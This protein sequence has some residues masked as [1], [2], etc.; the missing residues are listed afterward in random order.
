MEFRILGPLE[1][2]DNGQRLTLG[3]P[4]PRAVLA[5]LLLRAN[6]VVPAG[7]L[8]EALWGE[9][10]PPTA[11]T[12]VQVY[13]SR[14]RR[15][16]QPQKG[17]TR[18]DHIL[19]TRPPGYLLRVQPGGL[20]L[21]RFQDL[22]DAAHQALRD[23]DP[24]R[25][26]A[27]LRDALGLWRG[28][29]LCDVDAEALRWVEAPRLEEL[30]LAA[31][32]TRIDTE[33]RLGLHGHLIG[34]LQALVAAHPMRERFAGQ[35]MLA[36]Y[37]S[38]RK[39]DALEV[40]RAT[41]RRLIEDLGLEPDEDLQRLHRAILA[42]D[43]ELRHHL[44]TTTGS[45]GPLPRPPG[46]VPHELPSPIAEFTGRAQELR[47]ITCLLEV[48]ARPAGQ[49]VTI[50][51]VDG[52]GGIGKSALAIQAANQLARQYPDGQVYVNLHGATPGQPPLTPV[53]ALGQ[54]LRSLGLEPATIP[55]QVEEA[56]AR[57]RSLAAERR[58]LILLDNAHSAA[59]V[60]PLLPGSPTSAVLVTSRQVL[61]TL[62]SAHLV[63]LGLLPDDQALELLGRLVGP[64]RVAA[65]PAA[66]ADVVRACGRLPL[67]IRIAAARLAGRP[68]WQISELA[69]RLADTTRR[70][71]ELTAEGL[72]LR[73]AFDVSV[74]DLERS[75]D[76]VDHAAAAA[77]GLLS[78]PDGPDIDPPAAAELLAQPEATTRVLL[79]RLVDAHL[80]ETPQPGRYRFHDLVRLHARQHV[81]RRQPAQ[82]RRD[83]LTRLVAFYTATTWHTMAILRP[84]DRRLSI[85]ARRW[86]H[87]GQTFTS[88][89]E[90]LGWLEAERGNM[91]AAITQAATAPTIPTEL[92]GQL[93]LALHG[94]FSARS[95]WGDGVQAN[96]VALRLALSTGDRDGQAYAYNELGVAYE[97]LGRHQQAIDSHQASLSICRDLGDRGGQAA[98]LNNLGRVYELLG[99]YQEAI[100]SLQESL[101]IDRGLGHRRGQ[102]ASLGNLGHLYARMGRYQEAITSLQESLTAFR[103]LDEQLGQAAILSDFGRVYERMGRYQEAITSLQ[104]SLHISRDFGDLQTQAEGLNNLGRVYER[105]GRH[106]EAINCQQD[107]LAL[108]RR[109]NARHIQV[110]ALRDLGDTLTKAGR[111]QQ[112][113]AAWQ[114]AL[115]ICKALQIPEVAEIH[116]R[117]TTLPSEA[118]QAGTS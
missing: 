36:L 73:A 31:L 99:R 104:E 20:D 43:T 102:A 40:F 2:V 15:I 59:Q 66:A 72:A 69:G 30:R 106:E 46:P 56:A 25:A 90:A 19:M 54:L 27:G 77:F 39:A 48:P 82:E 75:S 14:L 16:L 33:L 108:S 79:E 67:A 70:L 87:G 74:E 118:D 41:R 68:T 110:E 100:T 89:P 8:I 65:E 80:M 62:E 50:S 9:A 86:T 26:A 95:Y 76:P 83:A 3:G 60:R 61:G 58:L 32:E 53:S 10:P 81:A 88:G 105:L 1:V 107:S 93:A 42:G 97:Y 85:A 34:E 6:M 109:S 11:T 49:P 63:H 84:G 98:S 115:S 45:T 23:G 17:P 117:L 103:E 7:Q 71:E 28:P 78:L 91:L 92:P 12:T 51:A 64:Q 111:A 44:G 5:M 37:R 18:Q 47:E 52:M 55:T 94:F 38:G 114:E 101:T 29:A 116:D 4:K 24:A 35:L 112:A 57:W 21:H 96:Q 113:R 22:V 13:V